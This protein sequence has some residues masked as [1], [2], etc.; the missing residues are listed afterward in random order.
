MRKISLAK[1]KLKDLPACPFFRGS[2]VNGAIRYI[3]CESPIPGGTTRTNFRAKWDYDMQFQNFCCEH[4]EKCEIGR[5]L[6][7]F[8]EDA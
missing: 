7:D 3:T 6:L 2:G 1:R 8:Y 4:Y 5:M